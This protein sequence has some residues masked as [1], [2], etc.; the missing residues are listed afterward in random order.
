MTDQDKALNYYRSALERKRP[1][2][3]PSRVRLPA[4]VRSDMPAFYAD[5]VGLVAPA[6]DHDCRSNQWGAISV[7]AENG[8]L[9]GVKPAEFDVIAWRENKP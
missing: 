3:V 8:R 2:Y 6:G 4:T 7:R 5:D 1:D 9:L